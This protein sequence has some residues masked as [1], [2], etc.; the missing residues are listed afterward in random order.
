MAKLD[1]RLKW[2]VGGYGSRCSNC[3]D[4]LRDKIATLIEIIRKYWLIALVEFRHGRTLKN[5]VGA[6]LININEPKI[7]IFFHI[8][9]RS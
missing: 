6:T 5:K 8:P 4:C 7:E 1:K 2:K 9:A 3:H